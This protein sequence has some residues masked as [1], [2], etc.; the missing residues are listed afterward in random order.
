MLEDYIKKQPIITKLLIKSINNNKLVQAYLFVSNDKIFLMEYALAFTKKIV[1]DDI[2]I[3]KMIDNGT[4]PELKIINPQ[5][6][7]IKKEELIKLQKD[8]YVKPT[9]GNKMVYIINEADKLNSSSANTILKFLEEPNDDVVAI[10][11]T[12]NLSKI[13]PTIKS[14]CQVMNLQN[15]N[16]IDISELNQ[17]YFSSEQL[18]IEDFIEKMKNVISFIKTI[19]NKKLNS[20]T[21][22]KDS[23]FDMFKTKEDYIF[24]FDFVLY[25]YYDILNYK[26]KR[27][28]VYYKEFQDEISNVSNNNELV[29]IQNKLKIIENTRLKLNSNMNLKLLLD[30]F[31]ILFSEV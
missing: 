21:N 20:I 5:N 19:E 2:S 28:L 30:E 31:I 12:D 10:L 9:I 16:T 29:I 13:L 25:F 23:T 18:S 14:R 8:F 24:L 6:N 1:S 7:I 11:L 27:N 3:H 22:Y 15:N 4:Y 26:L 17:R